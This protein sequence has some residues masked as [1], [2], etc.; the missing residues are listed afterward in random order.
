MGFHDLLSYPEYGIGQ[1]AS[2]RVLYYIG[3]EIF[4]KLDQIHLFNHGLID[5]QLRQLMFNHLTE[6]PDLRGMPYDLG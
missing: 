6:Y 3:I 4:S 1:H 5:G 2:L